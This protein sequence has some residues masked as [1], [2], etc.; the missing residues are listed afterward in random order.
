M[1]FVAEAFMNKSTHLATDESKAVARQA[2]LLI[3]VAR[4]ECSTHIE[5]LQALLTAF[6]TVAM[7]HDCCRQSAGS[8]LLRTGGWLLADQQQQ[9]HYQSLH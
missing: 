9:A 5:M 2:A 1:A 6:T 7:T 4:T 3:E 8:A